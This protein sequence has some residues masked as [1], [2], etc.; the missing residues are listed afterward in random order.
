MATIKGTVD[1]ISSKKIG[2]SYAYSFLVN[3]EWYRHG[4]E[5]PKFQKGDMVKFDDEPINEYDQIDTSSV[6]FKK[7]KAPER[8]TRGGSGG[9]ASGGGGSKGGGENWEARQKYWDDKDKRDIIKDD[10]YNYRSA[11]HM[12]A[13]LI[14]KGIDYQVAKGDEM[15][16]M[17]QLATPKASPAKKWEAYLTMIDQLAADLHAKFLSAGKG[18]PVAT[19]EDDDDTPEDDAPPA[20]KKRKPAPEPDTDDDDDDD[21]DGWEDQDDDDDDGDDDWDD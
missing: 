3:D 19:D 15:V 4:F 12:A 1:A 6:K 14:N 16:P 10:Q 18:G 7:G 13:E 20:K 2:K 5:K 17:L 11:F 9:K 21:D 8:K